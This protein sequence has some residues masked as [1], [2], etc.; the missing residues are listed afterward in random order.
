MSTFAAVRACALVLLTGAVLQVEDVTAGG[1]MVVDWRTVRS[2]ETLVID[3]DP[4]D[5]AALFV[6]MVGVAALDDVAEAP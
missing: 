3:A 5:T 1:G 2:G 6:V 4:F